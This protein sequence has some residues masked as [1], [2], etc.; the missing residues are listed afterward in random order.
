MQEVDLCM[1]DLGNR[2]DRD[3]ITGLGKRAEAVAKGKIQ[4]VDERKLGD[5]IKS[6]LVRAAPGRKIPILYL[7]D[8]IIYNVRHSNYPRVFQQHLP[9][10][11]RDTYNCV[12][13]DDKQRMERLLYK[14][15]KRTEGGFDRETLSEMR[16]RMN[17]N[18]NERQYK[19]L[20]KQKRQQ[21]QQQQ[22]MSMRSPPPVNNIGAYPIHGAPPHQFQQH[23]RGYPMQMPPH[24]QPSVNVM[25]PQ[26]QVFPAAQQVTATTIQTQ[27]PRFVDQREFL[28]ELN[29]AAS[30]LLLKLQ[31]NI[32]ENQH[33]SLEAV[34]IQ[35]NNF[36]VNL[37]QTALKD[38]E[39]RGIKKKGE[40]PKIDWETSAIKDTAFVMGV[41][42]RML[43][44]GSPNGI[45]FDDESKLN[46]LNENYRKQ[47]YERILLE[48]NSSKALREE[49]F[50]KGPQS[51]FWYQS[52]ADWI[53]GVEQKAA[54]DR[55]DNKAQ[56]QEKIVGR[57]ISIQSVSST[58]SLSD[59]MASPKKQ[60]GSKV[61]A[62]ENQTHCPI[63]GEAFQSKWDDDLNEW[64]YKNAVRPDPNGPIYNEAAY[65]K[66]SAN[67]TELSPETPGKDVKRAR[68]E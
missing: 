45:L 48:Q 18:F 13:K 54:V 66:R 65:L 38:L 62:D 49:F 15:E 53:H 55:H 4:G 67:M 6:R 26:P 10:I 39:D 42:S 34:R 11:F 14:W 33:L 61:V 2:P 35:D 52:T 40:A 60:I 47:Y 8:S 56:G 44:L 57:Q 64:V 63:S 24:S 25:P 31:Q 9:I 22:Y 27:G 21:L 23:P 36:Y 37:I 1:S 12:N 30:A 29:R 19:E 20:Q 17:P 16:A 5:Y 43:K 3:K 58:N 59:T 51:R 28:E 46:F 68:I 32:P 7:I 50:K 41:V